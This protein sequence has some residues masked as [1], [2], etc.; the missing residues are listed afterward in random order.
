MGM[1]NNPWFRVRVHKVMAA[2]G[3]G[4]VVAVRFEHPTRPGAQDGGWMQREGDGWVKSDTGALFGLLSEQPATSAKASLTQTLA[5]I[6][7][8]NLPS[9]PSMPQ[10]VT[11]KTAPKQES[12][13][14]PEEFLSLPR[15]PMSEV[16]KHDKDDDVWIVVKG[17]VYDA[18]K[19]LESHPG[20]ASSITMNA[21]TDTTEEFEA[22]HSPKAWADLKKWAIGI[23]DDGTLPAVQPGEDSAKLEDVA[24][25]PKKKLTVPL[26]ESTLV[27]NDGENDVLFLKFALPHPEQRLGLPTGQH[28]MAY[29][30]VD[31]KL[32]ARAY[33][34]ISNDTQRGSVDLVVKVYNTPGKEGK[35]SSHF[36]K[37]KLGDTIDIKGPIGEV[38]YVRPGVLD[39]HKRVVPVK[40]VGM[41][42]GGTGITPMFQ[43]IQTVLRDPEDK[44]SFHLIYAN[45]THEGIMLQDTLD[46]WAAE[47]PDRFTVEYVVDCAP[48]ADCKRCFSVGYITSDIIHE[49]I[50]AKAGGAGQVDLVLMCGPKPM[51]ERACI[52]NLTKMGFSEEQL[53]Q[54]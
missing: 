13:A 33:T 14:I 27:G 7:A 28:F 24:L 44:T 48:P 47:H 40:H 38:T 41:I 39:V 1:M 35:M 16:E 3:S 2:S 46:Q 34:P 50:C 18:T 22:I 20:G 54:F 5:P 36:G 51:I 4:Q 21:G 43:V 29:A 30:R 19:Y 53:V 37:M 49:S 26:V 6:F 25:Q 31:D 11:V 52:P 8:K 17:V 23:L 42:A 32:V 45:R 12:T 9:T 10:A 15:I